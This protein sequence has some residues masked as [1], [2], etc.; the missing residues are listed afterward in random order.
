M[1][2][3]S[4]D[5]IPAKDKLEWSLLTGDEGIILAALKAAKKASR[6][7]YLNEILLTMSNTHSA[8]VRNAAAIAVAD[9]HSERIKDVLI[10]LLLRD[11]TKK[12]R[13]TLLYVLD[14]IGA[15]LPIEVI[16]QVIATSRYEAQQEA[17]AFLKSGRIDFNLQQLERSID[18]LAK[19]RLS[20]NA[21]RSKAAE[22]ALELVAKLRQSGKR[23]GGR[24]AAPKLK[25]KKV[26]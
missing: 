14:E 6:R 13:G 11:D 9:F 5:F 18:T 1:S 4:S 17:L 20:R 21:E 26:A 16:T 19:L 15:S 24:K 25:I 23:R 7:K 12:S 8:R 3:I 2:T 22:R 10:N